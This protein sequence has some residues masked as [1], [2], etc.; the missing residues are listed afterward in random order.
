MQT[1]T[2]IGLDIAKSV[3]QVHGI[4]AE[5]KVLAAT[6]WRSS[7]G[8]RR[9][10]ERELG[11]AETKFTDLVAERLLAHQFNPLGA[12]LL[13]EM[14]MTDGLQQSFPL[15]Q[16]LLLIPLALEGHAGARPQRYAKIAIA[17]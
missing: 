12:W 2:T 5:G 9:A 16:S 8:C 4:D 7:R 15:S 3:F 17:G 13:T 1:V 10:W 14:G 6:S 11:D